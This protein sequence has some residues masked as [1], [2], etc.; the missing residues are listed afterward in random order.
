LIKKQNPFNPVNPRINKKF[1][2]HWTQCPQ[3]EVLETSFNCQRKIQS[4]F[5]WSCPTDFQIMNAAYR[6]LCLMFFFWCVISLAV[7]IWNPAYFLVQTLAF[8]GCLTGALGAEALQKLVVRSKTKLAGVAFLAGSVPRTIFP[9][10]FLVFSLKFY[11][12]PI[13]KNLQ[14][15]IISSYFVY[16]PLMLCACASSAIARAKKI[17]PVK[18]SQE[19][20]PEDENQSGNEDLG[21]AAKAFDEDQR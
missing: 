1:E 3:K 5:R 2:V 11:H 15:V 20:G 17:Q 12:Y 16:Y 8:I 7:L 18:D 9:V 14:Y 4:H 19:E 6:L 13:D 10:F 21:C